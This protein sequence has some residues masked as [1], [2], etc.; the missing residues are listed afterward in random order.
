MSENT[1]TDYTAPP[2]TRPFEPAYPGA[3]PEAPYGFFDDG[4]PR[5]RRPRAPGTTRQ[6][7]TKRDSTN[8][9]E[10]ITALFQI[11][12]FSLTLAGRNNPVYLADAA[13]LMIHGP[14]VANALNQL[15]QERPEVAAM[16]DKV[17]QVGPYGVLLA[18][19]TPMIVQIMTNHKMVP[20][21]I[22]GARHP[23]LLVREFAMENGMDIPKESVLA[24][25]NGKAPATDHGVE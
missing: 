13:A 4:R 17:L 9:T 18:A 12:A 5:K 22:M 6:R 19:V 16:L 14:N 7:S 8:Y 21:G 24:S 11:P 23:D 20:I 2:E 10:S 25:N 15:A 3:T 1:S